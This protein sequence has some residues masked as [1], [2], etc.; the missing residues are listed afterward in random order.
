[1]KQARHS[2]PLICFSVR[3]SHVLVTF[4]LFLQHV[5]SVLNSLIVLHII[6]IYTS[7]SHTCIHV[8]AT[9]IAD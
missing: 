9:T 5:H 3:G 6:I 7:T 4:Q 2:A 8:M 1:M